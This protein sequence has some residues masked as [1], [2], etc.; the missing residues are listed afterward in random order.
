MLLEAKSITLDGVTEPIAGFEV[1]FSTPFGLTT[2][3][4]DAI[5]RCNNNDIL[6]ELNISP[7]AVAVTSTR[8]YEVVS[9]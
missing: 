8:R 6:P 4:D 9:R 2:S 3:L 1:W 5:A 7:V